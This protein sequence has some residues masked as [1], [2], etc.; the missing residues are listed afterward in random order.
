M[1]KHTAKYE[2]LEEI[3]QQLTASLL[4]EREQHTATRERRDSLMQEVTLLRRKLAAALSAL[5]SLER[6]ALEG[7]E[8][9]ER[10]HS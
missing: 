1:A 4:L 6:F 10:I 8:R 2:A 7:R 3:N 5:E 9:V